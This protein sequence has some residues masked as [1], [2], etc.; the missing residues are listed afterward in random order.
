M[1][2]LKQASSI[3][4]NSTGL[5]IR[6]IKQAEFPN[7]LLPLLYLFLVYPMN[8][9]LRTNCVQELKKKKQRRKTSSISQ[10]HLQ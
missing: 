6:S 5:L 4:Q 1:N 8:I 7:F 3:M 10:Q 9:N 2:V